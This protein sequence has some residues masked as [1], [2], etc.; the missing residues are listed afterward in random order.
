MGLLCDAAGRLLNA[1]IVCVLT[2]Q[3]KQA[4]GVYRALF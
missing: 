3:T 4:L 2:N 1:L